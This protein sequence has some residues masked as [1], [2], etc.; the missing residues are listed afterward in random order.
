MMPTTSRRALLSTFGAGGI[1]A[2]LPAA[3]Q[4]SATEWQPQ[5][6]VRLVVPYGPGG[7]TDILARVLAPLLQ[8]RLGQPVIVENRAGAGT[9]VGTEHVVRSAPDGHTMMLVETA[10]ASAHTVA[11]AGGRAA[12]F[13][14]ARDLTAIAKLASTPA[15]LFVPAGLPARTVGEFVARASAH[16]AQTPLAHT[17][18]GSSTHLVMELLARHIGGG[19]TLVPYRGGGQAIQDVA[20]GTVHGVFLSW[21]AGAGLVQG[22]QV[23]ALGVAAEERFPLFPDVPTLREQGLDIVATFWWGLLGPAGLPPAIR[24]RLADV[25]SAA[26]QGAGIPERL[27]SLGVGADIRD[28]DAFQ[29]FIE[30][31]SARWAEVIRVA[32]IRPE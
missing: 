3:A 6:P 16:P 8:A 30:R 9:L 32:G 2:A 5:R 7:T 10:L 22:G 14:P 23:R 25:S 4:G 26:L 24:R 15:V 19:L 12:P 29:A 13:D 1:C 17:G 31:E 11:A 28:G 27:A 21:P 18:V 20:T